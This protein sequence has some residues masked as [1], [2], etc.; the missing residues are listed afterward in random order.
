MKKFKISLASQIFIGLILGIIVGGIFYGSETAQSILQPF[1]D[2][3]IRLIKMIVVPIVLS[4]II[5]A[6]AGVGDIK[7]VGKL[8]AKS[9]TY[10]IGMTLVAIAIGLISANIFQPGTG[11]NM[12][13]L[14]KTD[15]SGY[16]TTSEEQEGKSI[17]D[18]LLHIVPTNPVQAMVEGDMLAIIFFSVVF[19][20][21]VAAIGERGKPVLRVFE[22]V[23][24]AMFY[25]TNLFMKYAPIGVFALIGVTISKYGFTSLIPLG[26]LAITVYGTMIFF[27]VVILGLM[28]KLIGLN[29]FKLLKL[30]KEEL[31]LA[32][33]TSSSETV[34][35]RIMDKME[36][37]GS[38][39]HI[40][41]FVIPTGYSFNL[42]G[43]VLYQAIASL[44][45]AQMFGIELSIWQQITLMLVL[46]VTSKGM[47]GVPGVS[48]VVLLATFSTIGLPAA[49]L[50]FI[51]GIDRILDMGR[52]AVNVVG[53]SVAALVIAKWEGQYNPPTE[54]IVEDGVTA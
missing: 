18:T 51:A 47:A 44:F 42:D 5:V 2:L 50:A 27:V 45:I 3:F 54:E 4:S 23:A 10:F 28:A 15:I 35:P 8:G 38:P 7:S 32:F 26:K 1:G 46:M 43:S 19:G 24:H 11:L 12:D 49:G 20:L 16:V 29:I 17:A 9:L 34:L 31:L 36:Q 22:G 52:T 14:E 41:S 53:N 25:V 21:G 33:S 37:A 39:K 6:V 13:N 30:I 48:F 40:A